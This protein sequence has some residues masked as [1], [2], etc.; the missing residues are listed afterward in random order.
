MTCHEYLTLYSEL[1]DERLDAAQEASCRAHAAGCRSCAGYDRV[2]H[3]GLRL[4]RELPPVMPSAD[5]HLRVQHR[6]HHAQDELTQSDGI[7]AAGAPVA[8][9]IAGLIAFAAWGPLLHWA[10]QV[11]AAED[12][13]YAEAP[14][15]VPR[16]PSVATEAVALPTWWYA[17]PVAGTFL[18]VSMGMDVPMGGGLGVTAAFPGPYSP[19]IVSPPTVR[20]AGGSQLIRYNE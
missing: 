8:L 3:R 9:T 20:R 6:L 1:L 11:P 13:V 4:V 2:I 10:E 12:E 5:F 17:T 19:L 18:Y 7:G 16:E 14:A 15:T